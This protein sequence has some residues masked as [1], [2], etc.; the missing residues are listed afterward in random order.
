MSLVLPLS[1]LKTLLG[2]HGSFVGK[3]HKKVWSASPLCL[4]WVVWKARNKITF[5]DKVFSIQRLK[6]TFVY[7]LWSKTKLFID[8][9]P[10]T[11][12]IFFDWL[13]T[14]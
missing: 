5:D 14:Y 9:C 4:F 8:D 12:V 10:L 13:G 3:K 2:W 6:S 11:L 1:V 7:F